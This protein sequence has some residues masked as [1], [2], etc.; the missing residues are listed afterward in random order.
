[1]NSCDIVRELLLLTCDCCDSCH[2]DSDEYDYDLCEIE[3]DGTT[4]QVCCYVWGAAT[5][6]LNA[7]TLGAG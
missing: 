3:V 4:Y 1:M 5:S 7:N 2:E 6:Q